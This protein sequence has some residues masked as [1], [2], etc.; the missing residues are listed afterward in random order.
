MLCLWWLSSQVMITHAEAL[1]SGKQAGHLP[2]TRK[3]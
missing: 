1:F 2:A 3:Q